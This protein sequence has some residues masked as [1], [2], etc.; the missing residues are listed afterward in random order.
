MVV[1]KPMVSSCSLLDPGKRGQAKIQQ[2][3][4]MLLALTLFFVLV[5]LFVLVIRFAG[6]ADSATALEE[7]N[8]L[9]LSTKL[10][11]SPEFACGESFGTGRINC[12]DGDKAIAVSENVDAYREFWGSGITN[13]EIRRIYPEGEE[14]LCKLNNYPNCN[15]LRIISGELSG[16]SVENFVSFCRKEFGSGEVYDKCEVAKL[17][18][19][20]EEL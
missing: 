17:F 14:E 19:S 12:I 10:A 4:F 18:I 20:Y 9:L 8:A 3:A 15:V 16:F 13:I 7:K 11:N 6:I 1:K 2:M 5:G